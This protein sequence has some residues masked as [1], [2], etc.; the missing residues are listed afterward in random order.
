M[1]FALLRCVLFVLCSMKRA[2][3]SNQ[4]PLSKSARQDVRAEL[5]ARASGTKAC[6]ARVLQTLQQRGLL[7]D[8]HL[9]CDDEARKLTKAAHGHADTN[10]PYGRVVQNMAIQLV[11]GQTFGWEFIHPL[12]FLWYMTSK[13]ARLGEL[14][15]A[16]ISS[17]A[18]GILSLLL[19]GDEFTPGNP[20]RPDGGR[21]IFAFYY[22]FLEWPVWML[23]H[24]DAWFCFGSLRVN[25]IEKAVGGTAA[26]FSKIVQTMFTTTPA[27]FTD[28]CFIVV[29]G[30]E[31]M[32]RAMFKG[33]IADEKGL[34][35]AWDIKGQ[36]GTKPCISCQN[37]FNFIHKRNGDAGYKL[38]L[39]NVSRESWI[40]HTNESLIE[41]HD[42]VACLPRSQREQGETDR[43]LNYNPIGLIGQPELRAIIAPESQYFRDWQ[44][45]YCSNG[46]ASIQLGCALNKLKTD[47]VLKRQGIG[48][49]KITEYCSHYSLPRTRG[50]VST[51]WWD[52]HYLGEGYVRQ[53]AADVLEM[54][55]LLAAFLADVVRPLGRLV[56]DLSCLEKLDQI[57]SVL[58]HSGRFAAEAFRELDRL[59]GEHMTQFRELYPGYIKIKFHHCGHL[60]RDLMRLGAQISCFPLERKHRTLK[61]I[62]LYVFKN[63]ELA[64]AKDYVNYY[65][66]L[67]LEGRFRFEEYWLSNPIEALV[68][69]ERFNVSWRL[70]SPLGEIFRDDLLLIRKGD[71]V[72]VGSVLR[73]YEQDG[74]IIVGLRCFQSERPRVWTHWRIDAPQDGFFAVTGIVHNLTWAK[75]NDLLIRVVVPPAIKLPE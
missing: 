27:N 67:I 50:K 75:H 32:M 8:D 22:A 21:K 61:T 26:I 51:N 43:G 57:L 12:A 37:I 54:V 7:N 53:F 63:V 13:S 14:M 30:A 23:H 49:S 25:V 5:V 17:A 9:G 62:A 66:Q 33:I 15:A 20:L 34:K 44:H 68:G 46:V 35:E 19:Y 41:L 28:G 60:P 10:T 24:R 55:P 40:P 3:P 1:L 52:A 18:G 45:T 70:V 6:I 38:G 72:V 71:D 47:A 59:V 11:N 64:C 74:D 39:N 69:G 42:Q 36:A 58:K 16:A 4:Q 31:I 29:K 48:L 65:A 2:G 73:F 56:E